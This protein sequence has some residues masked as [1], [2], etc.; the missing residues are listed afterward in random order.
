MNIL[1]IGNK[2]DEKMLV[3]RYYP[4]ESFINLIEFGK[5]SFTKI[6]EWEDPWEN[7]LSRSKTEINGKL[8]IP[9][10]RASEH[11]Y[12]QCWTR[13]KES[14]AMWRIYSKNKTGVKISTS[15]SKFNLAEGVNRIGVENVMY[16]S[17]A[18]HLVELANAEKSRFMEA[19]FKRDAFSHEEEVRFLIHP[20]FLNDKSNEIAESRINLII[21]INRFIESIS[22]DPRADDW[23]VKMI[24]SYCSKNIPSC[25][26]DKS[27]LYTIQ[28]EGE[29]ITRYVPA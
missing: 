11:I 1:D 16:F 17:D 19:K 20:D 6:T 14:D 27:S 28:N 25:P 21:D 13:K 22:I 3:Y 7:V 10:Y 15:V 5:L 18:N 9:L 4:L 23:V 29:F 26:V 2:L 12:G 8:E 24:K